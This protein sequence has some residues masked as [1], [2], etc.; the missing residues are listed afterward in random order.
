MKK[1]RMNRHST[2]DK[3]FNIIPPDGME[4]YITVDF[5]DVWH[6][7]VNKETKAIIKV[8]NNH[9]G[10]LNTLLNN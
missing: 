6:Q 8:L 9:L 2:V 10:E 4:I 1:F 3:K 5:D 7:R